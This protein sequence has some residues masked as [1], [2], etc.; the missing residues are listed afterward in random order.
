MQ[1]VIP[2][3]GDSNRFKKSGYKVPKFLLKI[4]NRYIIEHVINLFPREKNFLFICNK[5]HLSSKQFNLTRILKK[6][7]PSGKIVGIKPHEFGPGYS[8]LEAIDKINDKE[9]II[10]NYCDFNCFWSYKNFKKIVRKKNYDGCI[11][12]YKDF[13]PSTIKNNY[14][15]YIKEIKQ[16]VVSIQEKR[17][18]TKDPV[19]EYTSSGTYYFKNKEILE[20][21]LREIL[22]K[23]IQI[24]GEYYVSMIYKPLIK[25]NMRVGFYKIDF[26]CQW[27]TPDDFNEYKSWSKKFEKIK[28]IK[29]K[30][31]LDGMLLI[32]AAGKGM[33]FIKDGF[34]THKPLIEISKKPILIQSILTHPN[35]K[36]LNVILSNKN[37]SYNKLNQKVKKYFPKSKINIL[38]KHTKGQAITCLEILKKEN[39]KLPITIGSCDT[40]LI[41]NQKKFLKLYNKLDTDIIVWSTTGHIES[42]RNPK[43]FG[44]IKANKDKINFVSVKKPLKNINYDPIILGT[45]TFKKIEYFINSVNSMIKRKALVNNEFYIDT[46]INDAIKLG[47][48]CK[49]FLVDDYLPWGTPN[50]Y[51]TFKYWQKYFNLWKNHPYT[52]K[53]SI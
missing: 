32:P 25:N 19:K 28:K 30:K 9:P 46:C 45:F 51:K 47:Y 1:I 24:N 21:N 3:V 7:C 10:I 49:I 37:K 8:I 22:K 53:N 34:T 41:Y 11:V 27:G 44:W 50:D 26:F 6:I 18:F 39:T 17:P 48:N 29:K 5:K 33:R 4:N 35:Y 14:Y 2:M 43:Q 12:V 13:H 38:N 52:I 15:A 16:K 20:K 23:K 31:E 42:I 36:N 40:G